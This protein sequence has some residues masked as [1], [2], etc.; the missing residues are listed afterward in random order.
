MSDAAQS[1]ESMAVFKT[2]VG[3]AFPGSHAVFRGCDLH[4]QLQHLGW[5]DLLLFGITGRRFCAEQLRLLESLWVLTS[6][7]DARLWNN[8]VAALAGTTRST[9]DLAMT[10]ALGV[11]EATIYGHRNEVRAL[12]FFVRTH[13][14]MQG[15][16]SLAECIADHLQQQGKLAGYGRPL[17]SGD[18][19]IAPTMALARELGLADGPHVTLA[20]E[21]DRF[22]QAQGHALRMN[23]GALVAALGADLG[24]S[25][26]EFALYLFPIFMAGMPPCYLEAADQPPGS[27]F[28]SDCE[29]IRYEGCGKR[30]WP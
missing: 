22:L 30:A 1:R 8:R 26:R 16:T 19:R 14:R 2:R 3:A 4:T 10:A 18:E 25:P 17:A 5:V 28:A 9:P 24:F 7:P 21:V 13:Q 20:F 11:S 15:G 6:Y 12:S 23:Y 29:A 27:V